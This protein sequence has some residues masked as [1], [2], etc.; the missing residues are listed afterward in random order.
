MRARFVAYEF[1]DPRDGR[2]FFVGAGRVGSPELILRRVRRDL[3]SNV[4]PVRSRWAETLRDANIADILD[5]GLEPRLGV[6]LDTEVRGDAARRAETA[7]KERGLERNSSRRPST[8]LGPVLSTK[9][10]ALLLLEDAPAYGSLLVTLARDKLGLDV[11][12]T[13]MHAALQ[14]L[15]VGGYVESHSRPAG[16]LIGRPRLWYVLTERGGR[17]SGRVR[18]FL[19]VAAQRSPR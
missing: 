5:A 19:L 8:L 14:G 17:A 3:A 6:L 9:A 1:S 11:A 10:V 12:W 15:E 13:A 16:T 7:A 4:R 18:E 2:V